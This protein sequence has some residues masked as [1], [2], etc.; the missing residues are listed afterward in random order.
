V[1]PRPLDCQVTLRIH[2]PVAPWNDGDWLI[3][4]FPVDESTHWS[5][6]RVTGRETQIETDAAG[7]ATIFCGY[8]SVR[9]AIEVGLLRV[10]PAAIPTIEALFGLPFPAHSLDH[11]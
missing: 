9:Q 5:C 8:L 1:T 7:I 2:D 4:G 6:R 10:E 3:T 11:F